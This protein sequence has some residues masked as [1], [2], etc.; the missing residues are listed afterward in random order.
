MKLFRIHEHLGPDALRL[1]TAATPQPGPGEI[2]IRHHALGV[3]FS[4]V[5][6][7][8][9]RSVYADIPLPLTPGVEGAGEVIATGEGV[10][11]YCPGDLVAYPDQHGAYAEERIIPAAAAI[12]LPT[13]VD[14][15]TAVSVLT[16]GLTAHLLA[17]RAHP[18]LNAGET[19]LVQ[20]GAGSVCTLLIPMLKK[21]GVRVIATVS[22]ETKADVA[23][24]VGAD[25]TI[26]Y[27]AQ[28]FVDPVRRATGGA[29]VDVVFDGVGK[30]TFERSL[31]CLRPRGYMIMFGEASGP[32]PMFAPATLGHRGS[33]YLTRV[34]MPFYMS[35]PQ[36][37]R[38]A[39]AALFGAVLAGEL[40]TPLCKAYPFEQAGEALK[41]LQHRATVGKTILAL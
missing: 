34:L 41:A 15:Q 21:L 4:D 12:A 39:S 23:A 8:L 20:A 18:G 25:V 24:E 37:R 10:D 26:D 14:A 31:D 32:P 19:A 11:D 28:D 36:E 1:E 22:S 38:E 9:G 16:S 40:R 13:G 29:G 3:N 35:D 2:L 27:S 6:A 33:L 30:T 17:H 5:Q 7:T